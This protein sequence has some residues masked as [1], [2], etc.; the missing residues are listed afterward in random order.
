MGDVGKLQRD[1]LFKKLRAKPENKVCFDC[2]AKNPTWSSVPYGV[3]ICLTCAGVH[4]SLGVHLSF[5]RSTTLDTWT[6]DQLKIMSV[7]GNGR[8]RQ[9]FKQHGWSELG[10]DKIEQKYTSRAAQLYRQQLTK[11]SAKLTALAAADAVSDS[12]PLPSPEPAASNGAAAAPTPAPAENGSAAASGAS[13]AAAAPVAAAPAPAARKPTAAKPRFGAVK[14][15]P[16]KSGGGLGVKKM[17]TKVDDSLF[18]QAPAAEAPPKPAAAAAATLAGISSTLSEEEKLVVAND[19]KVASRFAYDVLAN[20]DEATKA[21]G[22]KRGKDGHV[23]L[24]GADDF[25]SSPLSA[26]GSLAKSVGGRGNSAK[27]APSPPEEADAARK[28][29]GNAKSISSSQFN[30]EDDQSGN[31]Y[32]KEARLSRF[33]GA[34]AISSADFYDNGEGPSGGGGSSSASTDFDVSA[35]ELMSKLSFQA[36]QD[37]AQVKEVAGAATRKLGSMAQNFMKDL[38]GGY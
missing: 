28:R 16:A 30:S 19:S 5:V 37:F 33:Q 13:A 10:S 18:D 22:V 12:A 11:D 7:G 3:F 34:T 20:A 1:A 29:F 4:R 2:P 31:N 35:N 14:K 25:F 21:P 24:S 8:A 36:R 6:E 32:E 27:Q 17:T 15:P 23:Q 9:F 38:Q 26:K